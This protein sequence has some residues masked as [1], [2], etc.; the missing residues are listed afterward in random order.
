MDEFNQ[1]PEQFPIRLQKYLARAGA[2]SRRGSEDLMTSGQVTVNGEVVRELG[3][4]VRPGIDE[5]RIGGVLVNPSEKPS[6]LMLNK[7][8]GYLTTMDDPQGR[9][10]IRE[11]VPTD[12]IPGLFPVGRLDNDTTGLLLFMT[13]G[14]LAHRLLH[15]R[16]HVPKE[17]RVVVD[18]QFDEAS[19]DRL[20]EGVMLS[21]GLTLP[22][23]IRIGE[24]TEKQLSAREQLRSSKDTNFSTYV[25]EVFCTITEGRK[26][27]VKRMFSCVGHPVLEL[28]RLAFGPLQ[29]G[30]LAEGCWRH[31]SDD[32]VALLT[33]AVP[34]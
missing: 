34:E 18:G 21:D 30:D 33:A 16:R 23:I 27:Q 2:A 10:T 1:T 29:L 22:A 17:Y 24:L 32:E 12:E 6:Y 31:L 3:F 4:K 15:P 20:R 9:P 25:S 14:E 28:S 26:R 5:V 11:L 13:D 8:A 7:P 19:A